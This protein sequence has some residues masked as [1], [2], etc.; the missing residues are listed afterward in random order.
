MKWVIALA[1]LFLSAACAPR[2]YDG[3]AHLHPANT[4]AQQQGA[5]IVEYKDVG[6]SG[7]V[8]FK[9]PDGEAFQGSYTTIDD[10]VSTHQWGS[11]FAALD[12]YPTV[13]TTE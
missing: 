1:V 8:A 5:F 12:V 7:V 11:V 9:T 6:T 10:S 4:E 13:S 3:L 2:T